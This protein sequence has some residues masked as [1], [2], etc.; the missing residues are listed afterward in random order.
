MSRLGATLNYLIAACMHVNRT[1][2]CMKCWKM[3]MING[4]VCMQ[5][6]AQYPRVTGAA[7]DISSLSSSKSHVW[8]SGCSN[9]YQGGN[10][11]SGGIMGWWWKD[12]LGWGQWD[13]RRLKLL[14]FLSG[15]EIKAA[16]S[17]AGGWN[18]N[19]VEE[20]KG[21]LQPDLCWRTES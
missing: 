6:Q 8:G 10:F 2:T 4:N 12:S 16:A 20:K 5:R 14:F 9:C 15:D 21:P 11:T 3:E 13:G 7:V 18:W 1:I 17:R 19:T